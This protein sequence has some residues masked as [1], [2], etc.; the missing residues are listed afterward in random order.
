[1]ETICEDFLASTAA[2][3]PL[4]TCRPIWSYVGRAA[5]WR[6]I[7]AAL[8]GFL[9]ASPAWAGGPGEDRTYHV[10]PPIVHGNLAVF[11]VTAAMAHDT[12]Q[13]LTLDEGIRSGQV[14][15]T[16]AGDDRGIIRPGQPVPPR[17][18][19]GAEVNRLVL[20][21][22]S[23]RPLLLLAG[24]IVTGGKQDRVVASD[25]IVP[26]G[27]G[28]IDLGVFCVEPGRWVA[29]SSTFGSM[30]V[31]MAQPSVRTPAMAAR[32]QSRVWEN[33][34]ESNAKIAQNLSAPEAQ[35]VGGTSSYAKVF[36]SAPVA[37]AMAEY[38]GHEAEQSILREL[39]A[40]KAIGV[41]IAIN[42]HVM[43]AD[44]FASSD[45]LG[46]YWSKLMHS[47]VAEAMTSSSS[48]AAPEAHEADQFINTLGGGREIVETEA[49][50]FRRSETVGDG[51]RVFTLTS[52]LPK[53]GYE[54]HLTKLRQ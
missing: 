45:L 2:A 34:R 7:A 8:C 10:E 13:L 32:D 24:E 27:S 14:T 26:A 3:Q 40:R 38:G 23:S 16:E 37:K 35:A 22:N 25:R 28:P 1:M 20:S 51:Y 33:V 21:N 44:I 19:G 53:T 39:R 50:V 9:F 15:V 47:Y 4:S 43:W 17:H 36:A 42:G 54:V 52:L 5:D 46:K 29:S 11:P 6:A 12:T 48:A 18:G 30:G 49:D 41:V 31:Q